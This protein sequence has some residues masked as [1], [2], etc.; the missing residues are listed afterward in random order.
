MAPLFEWNVWKSIYSAVVSR[1]SFSVL[2]FSGRA[3]SA[4][5]SPF[6]LS[7]KTQEHENHIFALTYCTNENRLLSLHKNV[8]YYI[9][10]EA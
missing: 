3:F 2:A 5:P 6:A 4:P 7:G 9:S 1:P 8:I 10:R